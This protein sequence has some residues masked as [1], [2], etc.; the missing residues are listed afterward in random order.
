MTNQIEKHIVFDHVKYQGRNL[1]ISDIHGCSKTFK[2]LLEKVGLTK[3]DNLFLLGD[4][5]DRGIDS[6]VVLDYILSLITEGYNVF[7]LRGNHEESLLQ[8]YYEYDHDSFVKMLLKITKVPDML[9]ENQNLRKTHLEFIENLPYYYELNNCYLVHGGFDA[10]KVDPFNDFSSMIQTYID[11]DN[12]NVII[13]KGKRLIH[14]HKV[15]ELQIIKEKILSNAQVIPL[16]N[17]CAY[18]GKNHKIYDT[19]NLG[20]LCCLNIDSMEL[21]F[22][23]NIDF[24]N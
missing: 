23:P 7:P 9:D 24:N 5:I 12:F 13:L 2:A 18:F 3:S 15:T 16:D 22:Q 11:D 10:K 17:G 4:Y 19:S 1:V 20:N 21:T 14:G 8:A 6:R